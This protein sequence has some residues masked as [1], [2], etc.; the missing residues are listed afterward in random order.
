MRYYSIDKTKKTSKFVKIF[1]TAE[2]AVKGIKDNA[3]IMIG[4]MGFFIIF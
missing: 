1:E 3:T 2:D 4:G